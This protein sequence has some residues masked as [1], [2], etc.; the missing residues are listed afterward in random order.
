M[1]EAR[2][3]ELETALICGGNRGGDRS[4]S[5]ALS[6]DSRKGRASRLLRRSLESI[7]K[8]VQKV[9]GLWKGELD[10][11]EFGRGE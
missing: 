11:L 9:R 5:I 4:S 6:D 7:K 1:R 2:E 10:V 3:L 8:G